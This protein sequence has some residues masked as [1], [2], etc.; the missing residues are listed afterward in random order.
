MAMTA[1]NPNLCYERKQ[2]GTQF[3]VA[4]GARLYQGALVGLNSSGLAGPLTLSNGTYPTFVGI[5]TDDSGVGDGSTVSVNVAIDGGVLRDVSV[6][7]AASEANNGAVVYATDENTLTLSAA[8]NSVKVGRV[9]RWR[10]STLCH[11]LIYSFEK[12]GG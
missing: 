1:N 9:K 4:N 11:V 10:S 6:A 8:G 12:L 7:T 3:I 2:A 5:A